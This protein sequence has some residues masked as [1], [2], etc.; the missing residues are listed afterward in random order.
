M[1]TLHTGQYLN[2]PPFCTDIYVSLRKIREM[3]RQLQQ[4]FPNAPILN[5][6]YRLTTTVHGYNYLKQI[7]DDSA[8][9]QFEK[10]YSV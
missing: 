7:F 1:S 6:T 9:P 2:D 8:T 4:H 5:L 10:P 3:F